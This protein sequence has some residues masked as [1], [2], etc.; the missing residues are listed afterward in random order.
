[1]PL[2]AKALTKAASETL[3]TLF[4][5]TN[6]LLDEQLDKVML[7]YKTTKPVFY[8]QY[9]NSRKLPK[10]GT[11]TSGIIHCTVLDSTGNPIADSI[12]E[13]A[14]I[15]RPKKKVNAKGKSGYAKI[16]TPVTVTMTA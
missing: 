6:T 3:L 7:Q 8:K 16:K 13:I 9:K 5:N 10:V 12:L 15:S 11:H 4:T 2:T 14:G 1:M